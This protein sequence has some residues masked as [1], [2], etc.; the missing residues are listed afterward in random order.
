LQSE[1]DKMNKLL[2]NDL[3]KFNTLLKANN[4]E[5]VKKEEL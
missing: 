1:L 3:P 5:P 2:N 4:L